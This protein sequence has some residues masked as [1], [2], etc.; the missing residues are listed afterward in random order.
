MPC[1]CSS[2]R[3][4]LSERTRLRF[5]WSHA[6]TPLCVF[7]VLAT[8]LCLTWTDVAIARAFFFDAEQGRWLG[9]GNWWVDFFLHTGGRWAVRFLVLTSACFWIASGIDPCL[10]ATRRPAAYF[11]ASVLLSVAVVG[12]LKTLTNVDCPWDL[13]VF[14]GRYP[15]IRL[16]ADRPDELP[17]GRCFPAAHASSGYALMALYFVF[18]ERSNLLAK[19]GLVSGAVTGLMFGLA[20]QSR[21]AHFISHDL[22]SAIITW[23]VALTVY[24]FGFEA[25]LWA[26]AP[27]LGAADLGAIPSNRIGSGDSVS[28]SARARSNLRD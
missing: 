3:T 12:L 24:T 20:Q 18:R 4:S 23:L 17:Q 26:A 14:G 27:I 25:R 19:L 16:F 11:A 22:W 6:C 8:V 5:W 2:R 13:E 28:V 7:A 10:R 15:L 21:G 1:N 9:A